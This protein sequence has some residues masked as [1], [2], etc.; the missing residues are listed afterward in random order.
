MIRGCQLIGDR[1]SQQGTETFHTLA[2]A[3]GERLPGCFHEATGDEVNTALELAEA[4]ADTLRFLSILERARL[5]ELIGDS[6]ERSRH[7]IEER[8]LL[9]TGYPSERVGMEFERMIHLWKVF[10]NEV[11]LGHSLDARID[12]SDP[13]RQ[14]MPKPDLRSMRVAV[15]SVVVFGASNFPLALSVGGSDVISAL[16]AGC[17]V[18]VKG[19]PS[20]PG[21]SE[22]LGRAVLRGIQDAGL[23]SGIF[24]LIQG[25]AHEVGLALAKHPFT[26]AVGFTGSL[27]GGRALMDAASSRPDPIPVYAEMGSVN[28]QF[29]FPEILTADAEGFAK[30]LFASVTM[31]NGQFCTCPG[32]IVVPDGADCDAFVRAYQKIISN[33]GAMPFLNP[34]IAE[35]Y[36]AGVAD[37]RTSCQAKLHRSPQRSGPVLAEVSWEMFLAHRKALLEEVFGPSTV[38]IRCPNPD[39][40]L[41]AAKM[42]PGQLGASIHGT[43]DELTSVAKPLLAALQRFAGRIV[44]NGFPTG[45]ETAY[46]M[47][48]GGPYPATSDPLHTSLGLAAL[49]RWARPV[50]FQNVPEEL[51]PDALKEANPLGIRR[52]VEG[53]WSEATRSEL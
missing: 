39:A 26:R 41:E 43:K 24:S 25:R 20:H 32:V 3:S 52:L 8:C 4:H 53:E 15:G 33:S 27:R 11:R 19:H 47:Q 22:L 36:E 18:V 16:G 13:D 17:P 51:L 42:L 31:G 34:G 23:P 44:I 50:C 21:T 38:L 28:P 5:V 40:F 2:P 49:A 12:H 37:W 14:P 10:A 48:H 35:A 30:Q 45:I 46:A 9:E 29:V 1:D 6:V 7:Q